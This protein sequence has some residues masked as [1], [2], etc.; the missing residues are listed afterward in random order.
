M[1][2]DWYLE[3]G[4]TYKTNNKINNFIISGIEVDTVDSATSNTS[5][6]NL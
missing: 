1:V 5:A 2:T 4:L 3:S 6:Y